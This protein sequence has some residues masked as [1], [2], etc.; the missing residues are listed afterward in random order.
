[1]TSVGAQGGA[2]ASRLPPASTARLRRTE[3]RR[4]PGFLVRRCR[5][6]YQNPDLR[7]VTVPNKSPRLIPGAYQWPDDRSPACR[8]F[9]LAIQQHAPEVLRT[10]HADLLP[11]YRKIR[12][13]TG[14][15][16]EPTNDTWVDAVWGWAEGHH[17]VVEA[18]RAPP[19]PGT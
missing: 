12:G 17:L 3:V 1:M 4:S 15:P 11:V 7:R 6:E 10:L 9:F 13:T 2:R 19:G 16:P 5:S 18:G 8:L 14:C